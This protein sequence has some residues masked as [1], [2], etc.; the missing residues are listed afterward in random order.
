MAA[1]D[2]D[3]RQSG[4]MRLFSRVFATAFVLAAT[5]ALAFAFFYRTPNG[6]EPFLIAEIP[7]ATQAP[8]NTAGGGLPMRDSLKPEDTPKASID[9]TVEPP[10]VSEINPDDVQISDPMSQ[11]DQAPVQNGGGTVRL[12]R[13]PLQGFTESGEFGPLPKISSN[14]RKPSSVYAR[15]FNAQNARD[16]PVRIAIM[17]SG[18]GISTSSTADAIKH[19]PGE[20]TLAFAPYGE[21]LQSWVNRAR[22]GGHEVMLQVP[23]EP[24]DFPDNDPG[25]HTLLS[26]LK[27]QENLNRLRW[28]LSRFGGYF[29]VTNY[30][31]AKFTADDQSLQ[32]IMVELGSRGLSFL[33]DGVSPRSRAVSVA[34]AKALDA[35]KADVVVDA[36]QSRQS[37]EQALRR[38]EAIAKERGSAIGVGSALPVTVK[39][40]AEWSKSLGSRGISLAPVSALLQ[41]AEG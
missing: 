30:M 4:M 11:M 34:N 41:P 37:I 3:G 19:L 18:M 10:P 13:A 6:G 39:T 22:S 29:G 2:R 16:A 9:S 25:P 21:S 14:G 31:G 8:V 26:H 40:I 1:I 27:S 20:V 23:M 38:L 28:L 24:F 12:A 35:K 33:D 5:G 7:A 32:P 15:P 36:G 17:V